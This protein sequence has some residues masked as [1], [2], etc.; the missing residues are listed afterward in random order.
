MR[1]MQY[2]NYDNIRVYCG[3]TLDIRLRSCDT[4]IVEQGA[5]VRVSKDD[6]LRQGWCYIL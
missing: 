2:H 5:V 3:S 1:F 4:K 6:I